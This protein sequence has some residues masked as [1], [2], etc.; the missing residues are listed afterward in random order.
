MADKPEPKSATLVSDAIVDQ[1]MKDAGTARMV[2]LLAKIRVARRLEKVEC[3]ACKVV[4]LEAVGTFDK[5]ALA[6]A[7]GNP[8]FTWFR[9]SVECLRCEH[10]EPTGL[11]FKVHG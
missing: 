5:I 11:R 9:V 3:P 8:A 10:H 1:L 4:A 7:N 2:T 6:S